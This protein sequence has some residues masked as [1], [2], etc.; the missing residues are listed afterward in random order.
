M[1]QGQC[2]F[3]IK[4][5]FES[6]Q[7]VHALM[8]L[9]EKRSN[10]KGDVSFR[11]RVRIK[12]TP[13]Q[14][15]TF[16]KLSEA[17]LWALQTEAAIREQRYFKAPEAKRRTLA[18]LIT[19]YQKEVL[20]HKSTSYSFVRGQ[21]MQLNW[22]KKQL[23]DY[24]LA[25]VTA[26]R[27][28]EVR[29]RLTC[30]ASTSNRYMAALSH[31]FTVAMCEWEWVD[32]SPIRKMKR[33]REPRGRVRYLSDAERTRLL[34]TARQSNRPFQYLVI[35]LALSTGARKGEL[36]NLRWSDIDFERSRMTFQHTKNGERRSAPLGKYAY[37]LLLTH[38]QN[39]KSNDAYVFQSRYD[40][41]A[42]IDRDFR[43]LLQ[44]C[45]IEDF[46]FHDLRHSAASY[47]AMN[48]ASMTD[49]AEV[50]GH[51]TLSMVK[52]YTHLSDSHT[53]GVVERMNSAI[54]S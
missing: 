41:P 28:S 53:R 26:A 14:M 30:S 54:F 6:K 22:W 43:E 31:V 29:S 5:D 4:L 34:D 24:F 52:R 15:A 11:V 21:H 45:S 36:L 32:E 3:E 46:R 50:L 51:K 7:S 27:I 38:R 1:V 20:P 39:S 47:L 49:I 35:V 19:R 44:L 25:D 12:G 16:H 2:L 9:I 40:G 37:Q 48:G 33:L 17:K 10:C 23:G 42:R 18:E 13:Q 8:A